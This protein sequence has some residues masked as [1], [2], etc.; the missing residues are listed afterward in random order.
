MRKRVFAPGRTLSWNDLTREATGACLWLVEAGA[1]PPSDLGELE[2]WAG[3]AAD[4]G[5]IADRIVRLASRVQ[6]RRSRSIELT[7]DGVLHVGDRWVVPT[8]LEARLL[9]ALLADLGHLVPKERLLQ[10]GWGDRGQ[11]ADANSYKVAMLRIRRRI[12][13]LELHLHAVAGRGYVLAPA[14]TPRTPERS[15]HSPDGV[16]P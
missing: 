13:P 15:L 5:E 2:D 14:G 3:A 11:V 16:L 1:T 6:Q 10:A 4:G 8:D 9:T 7:G 12:A